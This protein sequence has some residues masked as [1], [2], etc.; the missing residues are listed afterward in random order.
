MS[1]TGQDLALTDQGQYTDLLGRFLSAM[2]ANDVTTATPEPVARWDELVAESVPGSP[3]PRPYLL[4]DGPELGR[5]RVGPVAQLRA[6]TLSTELASSAQEDWEESE[7]TTTTA[8]AVMML[9]C[10]EEIGRLLD[11]RHLTGDQLQVEV[12]SQMQTRVGIGV[13]DSARGL[14][15]HRYQVDDS[16]LVERATILTPTAQNEPWLAQMLQQVLSC[17]E[18]ATDRQQVILA[19]EDAIRAADPCLPCAAAPPGTMGL[20]IEEIPAGGV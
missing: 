12:P 11:D 14:L 2:T 9:Y 13:V 18:P 20:T 8:R 17:A 16:G 19:M 5:Y 6:G 7:Q 3:A 15:V 4:S 10:V 1:F